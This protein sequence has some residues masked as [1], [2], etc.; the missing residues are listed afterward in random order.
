MDPDAPSS[1]RSF[2]NVYRREWRFNVAAPQPFRRDPADR[3]ATSLNR[4]FPSPE[5]STALS[6]FRRAEITGGEAMKISELMT[7]EPQTVTPDDS[8]KHAAELMDR[9]DI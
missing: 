1:G 8:V 4:R 7:P 3:R 5:P 6:G 9:F 2:Q